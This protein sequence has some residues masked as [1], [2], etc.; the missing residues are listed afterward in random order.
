MAKASGQK[1]IVVISKQNDDF[2]MFKSNIISYNIVDAV[3]LEFYNSQAQDWYHLGGAC[4][5]GSPPWDQIQEG[6]ID[7]YIDEIAVP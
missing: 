7:K 2:V 4:S 6:Y 3:P 5:K 1:Y